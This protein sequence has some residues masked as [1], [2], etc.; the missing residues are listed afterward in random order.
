LLNASEQGV[1]VRYNP[2]VMTATEAA[3]AAQASCAKY[4]RHAVPG[5]I[6][7]TGEVFATFSC[8]R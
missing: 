6:A 7:L 5:E 3:V 1:I 2:D 4:G 8:I